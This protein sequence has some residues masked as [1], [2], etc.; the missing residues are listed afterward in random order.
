[1]THTGD[2]TN[3]GVRKAIVCDMRDLA[4]TLDQG[5]FKQREAAFK[6]K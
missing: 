4:R 3:K 1:M 6:L 2:V 5:L